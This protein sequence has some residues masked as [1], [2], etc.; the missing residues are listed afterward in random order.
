MLK[1]YWLFAG[2]GCYP[3]G[4]INDLVRT[5]NRFE[6]ALDFVE[7]G[8]LM[9]GGEPVRYDPKTMWFQVFDSLSARVFRMRNGW[10]DVQESE[11]PC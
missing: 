1:R 4:G 2:N 3:G 6:D 5:F 10:T 8:S 11:R 7:R 9:S